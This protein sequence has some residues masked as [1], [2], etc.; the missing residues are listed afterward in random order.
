MMEKIKGLLYICG[1]FTFTFFHNVYLYILLTL[2]LFV[3][4]GKDFIPIVKRTLFSITIFSSVVTAS[5]VF[6]NGFDWQYITL[7][8]V[9]VFGITFMTFLF[10]KRVNLFKLFSFSEN[11]T[12]IIVLSYS[13]ILT[14]QKHLVDFRFALK[15]RTIMKPDFSDRY[16]F[17]KRVVEF[18]MKS[19][20]DRSIEINM[21]MKSRG[22]YTDG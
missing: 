18:F 8:N 17:F 1:I 9:R 6:I 14:F 3:L 4:S 11:L 10:I 19:S 21:A 13:Q 20:L 2:F 7:V 16:N 22:F 5:Y 12:F 15:S